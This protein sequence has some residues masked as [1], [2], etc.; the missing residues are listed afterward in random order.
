LPSEHV[1]TRR[2]AAQERF[3]ELLQAAS[4]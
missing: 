2:D 1:P 3:A 4:T